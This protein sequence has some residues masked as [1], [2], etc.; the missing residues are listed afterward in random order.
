MSNYNTSTGD[1]SPKFSLSFSTSAV[2]YDESDMKTNCYIWWKYSV[3]RIGDASAGTRGVLCLLGYRD[4]APNMSS[5]GEHQRS[6]KCKLK[7]IGVL[8][9]SSHFHSSFW[10]HRP[11]F[12]IDHILSQFDDRSHPSNINQLNSSKLS[13]SPISCPGATFQWGLAS[14]YLS[15]LSFCHPRCVILQT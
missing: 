5:M 2:T 13:P 14:P 8:S 10:T 9:N 12:D 7:L 4:G 3:T 1:P 11:N 15:Y 6:Q